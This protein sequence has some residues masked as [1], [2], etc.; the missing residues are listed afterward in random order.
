MAYI[1]E[2]MVDRL[3]PIM[4]RDIDFGTVHDMV[5]DVRI[6]SAVLCSCIRNGLCIH[7]PVDLVISYR[8]KILPCSTVTLEELRFN[9]DDVVKVTR[10]GMPVCGEEKVSKPKLVEEIEA[11][12]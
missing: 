9:K 10:I 8:D 3:I 5:V 2:E 1:Y 11:Y 4:V 12:D 6:P 7:H